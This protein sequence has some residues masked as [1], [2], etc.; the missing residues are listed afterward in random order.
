LIEALE[1]RSP[2]MTTVLTVLNRLAHKGLVTR[3]GEMRPRRY[4]ATAGR[5]DYV[6][7]LMLDALGQAPDR[8]AVLSRFLGAMSD[9]DTHHLRRAMRRR[10]SED[11]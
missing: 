10:S 7:Q 6:A 2:A 11:N 1:G 3:A 4:A 5:E 8:A 9:A